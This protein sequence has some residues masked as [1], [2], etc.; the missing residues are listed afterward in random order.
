MLLTGLNNTTHV[1]LLCTMKER[2][3]KLWQYCSI[4]KNLASWRGMHFLVLGFWSI[5]T[6]F[7]DI[8]PPFEPKPRGWAG[9][10]DILK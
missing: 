4:E 9:I 3:S 10:K 6:D 5:H 8:S 2:Y 1:T 7:D